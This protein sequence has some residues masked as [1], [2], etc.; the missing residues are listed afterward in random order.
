MANW[1]I[2]QN[3]TKAQIA[4]TPSTNPARTPNPAECAAKSTMTTAGITTMAA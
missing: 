4:G 2:T 1:L 3:Q